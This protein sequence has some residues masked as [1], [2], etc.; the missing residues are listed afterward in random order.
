MSRPREGIDETP[1][2]ARAT[3]PSAKRT[4]PH[5][6]SGIRSRPSQRPAPVRAAR[7]MNNDWTKQTHFAALDWAKDHHDVVVVDR[8]GQIALEFRF[9]HTA[10]GWAEFTEK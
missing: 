5:E 2:A 8:S 7:I 3:G 4:S 1:A 9:A 10:P 6:G